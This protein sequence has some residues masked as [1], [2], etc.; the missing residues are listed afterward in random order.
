MGKTYTAIAT[1]KNKTSGVADY[2]LWA[3]F[4]SFDV[5]GIRCPTP[6]DLAVNNADLVT[7]TQ[8]HVF[9]IDYG[10]LQV[11]GSPSKN[12]YE[13]NFV[14]EPG[15]LKL[16]SQLKVFLPGSEAELHAQISLLMN[17]PLLVLVKDS[18]C[19]EEMFYQLGCDCA[20]A[21]IKDG[22]FKTGT[23]KDGVKGWELMIEYPTHAVLIYKGAI[24][25]PALANGNPVP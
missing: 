8:T 7:I 14:G 4:N 19:T 13:A 5:G 22:S 12:S 24:T 17:E 15:S 25:Y 3:P 18:N 20:G 21:Y 6:Y 11:N 2:I 1:K 10:F 9:L 16:M 23:N